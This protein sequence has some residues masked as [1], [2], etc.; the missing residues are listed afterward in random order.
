[1]TAPK[2]TPFPW[3]RDDRSIAEGATGAVIAELPHLFHHG[4][5]IRATD[6]RL[7][8]DK[9]TEEWNAEQDANA[10]LILALPDFV[11]VCQAI[12]KLNEGQGQLNLCQIAGWARQTLEKAGL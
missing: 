5:T 12:G 4:P 6:N 1:M 3:K 2:H 9:T 8:S 7:T 10:A 11:E